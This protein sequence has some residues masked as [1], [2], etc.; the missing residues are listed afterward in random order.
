LYSYLMIWP[1]RCTIISLA[2]ILTGQKYHSCAHLQEDSANWQEL[3]IQ[4]VLHASASAYPEPQP[5]KPRPRLRA[6]D[7]LSVK[8]I[9]SPS[10]T[11]LQV[12]PVADVVCRLAYGSWRCRCALCL[13]A[14]RVT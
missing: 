3:A 14:D 4:R 8:C 2:Q 7:T 13:S 10:P 1:S 6:A 5:L 11:P 12:E 9:E